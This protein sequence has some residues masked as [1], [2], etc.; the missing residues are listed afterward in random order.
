MGHCREEPPGGTAGSESQVQPGGPIRPSPPGYAVSLSPQ[1][2]RLWRIRSDREPASLLFHAR[3]LPRDSASLQ[4]LP[5]V[6]EPWGRHSLR[7]V[8]RSADAAPTAWPGTKSLVDATRCRPGSRNLSK[9]GF[10]AH[11]HRNGTKAKA[12]PLRDLTGLCVCRRPASPPSLE[13]A[14]SGR[15]REC[16]RVAG[17]DSA[18]GPGRG[19]GRSPGRGRGRRRSLWVAT[20]KW[21]FSGSCP[22]GSSQGSALGVKS[23]VNCAHPHRGLGESVEVARPGSP[24]APLSGCLL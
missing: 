17:C 22:A 21:V 16:V 14:Q 15:R 7:R 20:E 11:G 18:P 2:D 6:M 8:P 12:G 9:W 13:P 3:G 1:V 23:L 10:L 24:R 5:S 19:C 4:A